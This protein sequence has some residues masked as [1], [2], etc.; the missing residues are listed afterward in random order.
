MIHGSCEDLHSC[1]NTI[2]HLICLEDG[3][4]IQNIDTLFQMWHEHTFAFF[5]SEN[6]IFPFFLQVLINIIL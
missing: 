2:S 6:S 3:D 1:L 4:L 5:M